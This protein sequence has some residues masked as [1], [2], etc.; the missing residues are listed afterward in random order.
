MLHNI[1]L[2][3]LTY[4]YAKN[5]DRLSSILNFL[6]ILLNESLLLEQAISTNCRF[7]CTLNSTYLYTC[8]VF[9]KPRFTLQ[10]YGTYN[11][12]MHT[13]VDYLEGM[14]NLTITDHMT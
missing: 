9:K 1:C 5:T 11:V 2:K 10:I 14:S 7:T 8:K 6:H 13:Y 12:Q 3:V 4:M